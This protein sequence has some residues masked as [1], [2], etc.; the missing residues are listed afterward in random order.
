LPKILNGSSV[1]YDATDYIL[2]EAGF[3]VEVGVKFEAFIDGCNN[4]NGS[5]NLKGTLDSGLEH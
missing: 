4:R 1:D 5:V 2:L 3:E